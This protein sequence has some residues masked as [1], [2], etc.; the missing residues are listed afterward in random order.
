M[1]WADAMYGFTRLRIDRLAI[2][3]HLVA[4]FTLQSRITKI[5]RYEIA[6]YCHQPTGMSVPDPLIPAQ[7]IECCACVIANMY[8]T[9]WWL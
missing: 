4:G 6:L 1:T 7:H 8:G 2:D 3:E 5:R 9:V